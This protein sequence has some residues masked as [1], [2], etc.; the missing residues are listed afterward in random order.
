[1]KAILTVAVAVAALVAAGR[2]AAALEPS[3]YDPDHT[4]CVGSSY[5]NGVLHLAKTCATATNAAAQADITGL[6]GQGF[7]SATFTL[8]STTQCQGGSPRFNVVTSDGTF[9]LGCNNVAPS[10]STYLFTAQTLAAAGQQVPTPT[11]TIRSVQIV[12]DVQGSA[13]LAQIAVNGV[14]QV[15]AP[16]GPASKNACKRGGWRSFDHPSFRNQGQCVSWFNHHA[17]VHHKHR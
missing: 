7:S 14:T 13:D 10:G 9:F 8:A 4:G 12:L 15:P 11:G 1:M 2:T 6:A 17:K 16:V 5:A 3:V